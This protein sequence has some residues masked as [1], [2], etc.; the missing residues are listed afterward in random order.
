MDKTLI[1]RPSLVVSG[2]VLAA[3][4]LFGIALFYRT[5][6]LPLMLV[7]LVLYGLLAMIRPVLAL[8]FVP[9]TAPLYLMPVNIP[10]IRDTGFAL[11][12]HEVAL[13]VVFGAVVA[14]EV[15]QR[16]GAKGQAA[17]R[18]E[19]A[20]SITRPWSYAPQILFLLAG[21]LGLTLA[22]ANG[23]AERSAALRDMRWFI[24]EP[25]IFYGLLA[26]LLTH[27]STQRTLVQELPPL[28]WGLSGAGVVVSLLGLLQAIGID[29][30]EV[31]F[32][33]KRSFSDNTVEAGG[34]VRV[35]SVYG[36]PN[37][38]GMFLGRVWP[39]AAALVLVAVYERQT[40]GGGRLRFVLASAA[41]LV[42]LAGLAVSFSRGAWLGAGAALAVLTLGWAAADSRRPA[43]ARRG[44]R[45]LLGGRWLML[46]G[47]AVALAVVAGLALTLRGGILGGSTPP[48]LLIWRESLQFIAQRP[49]GLG[50]D[51][52]YYYHNPEFGRNLLDPTLLPESD[53]FAKHPHN[54]VL[55]LWLL[56]TPFGLLAVGWMIARFYRGAFGMLQAVPRGTTRA[57]VLGAAASMTA[58]LVHGLVDTF[59]FWPDIAYCFWLLLVLLGALAARHQHEARVG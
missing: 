48:R 34:V 14:S 16:F 5:D 57:L 3:G 11:P 52:F 10:G 26:W 40:T 55:E 50:L 33:W 9:A 56:L 24:I 58:A 45:N 36:H 30:T 25:L 29:L 18:R 8:A 7:G 27:R 31:V 38:L 13:L 4:M 37:N 28:L 44:G 21:V 41:T 22:A 20:S 51:Q 43:S 6:I 42:C 19:L 1:Q 15:W 59:Y 49:L 53:R 35:A 46:I 54:L 47:L 17:E 2:P 39:L 23:S 32:N 12:V